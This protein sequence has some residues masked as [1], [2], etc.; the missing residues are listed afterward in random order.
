MSNGMAAAAPVAQSATFRAAMAG[1]AYAGLAA[2]TVAVAVYT[3]FSAYVL[4]LLMQASTYSIAVLGLTIVLGY[5]GQISLAKAAFFGLGAYA[6]ALG[7]TVLGLGFWL[8]LAVGVLGSSVVGTILGLTTLRLGGHYLAMV[9]ISFQTIVSLVLTNWIAVTKG[10]DGVTSIPRPDMFAGSG[11][12]LGLCVVTLFAVAWYVW[13][14]RRTRLGRAM[15][16]TRDNELA[17]GVTGVDTYRVKV[18]AFTLSACLGSLGGALFAGGF[19][20]ISPDQFSFSESVVFLTM[21]LL[22]GSRSPAGTVF[23][24]TLLILL[25]EW[26][27]FLKSVYLAVYGAAVILIM[28]FMPD[29]IWGYVI[30]LRRKLFTP[31]QLAVGAIPPLPLVHERVLNGDGQPILKVEKLSKHFGGL[32]AVDEVDLEV[33]QNSV[34]ALIGPNGSGK[35]TAL[36]VLSG[37][38][39]PTAGKVAFEGIDIT[40]LKP[41]RRAGCGMGRTFQNIRLFANMSVLDN[42]IVGAERPGNKVSGG[43]AGLRMRA[44]SALDFVGLAPRAEEAVGSLSYGHQRLVEV[45]RA[46]AGNPKLLLLDEPGAGLNHVEKADLVQLLKRLRGHGLTVLIIDHDMNLV[47]QVADRI[48]VLNFGRH[49]ADGAPADVLRNPDVVSAYLGTPR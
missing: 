39:R 34:H 11:P 23:G 35:T 17:A 5:T 4:N 40:R 37:I 27:R 7:T 42:V 48:T 47:E 9:T 6:V 30:L 33:K 10:P 22:G 43:A 18:A 31:R 1:V 38:Y 15:Q 29:G 3:P 8:S 44:L 36:N 45:A 46:L 2:V 32:K 13:F 25:P 16:A 49:I 26:L 19:S 12:Y 41:H 24:T 14:L 21:A 20:Y 28:V